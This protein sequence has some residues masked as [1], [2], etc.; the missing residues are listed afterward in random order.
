MEITLP[1]LVKSGC[2]KEI[3]T[4]AR[5]A[6]VHELIALNQEQMSYG[7]EIVELSELFFNEE[8]R[9]DEEAKEVISEEQVPEV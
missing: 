3:G 6:W 4:E 1:H 8:V 5:R 7:A 9:M 2:V